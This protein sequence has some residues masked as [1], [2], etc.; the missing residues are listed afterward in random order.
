MAGD[1]A[2]QGVGAF[3]AA[4]GFLVATSTILIVSVFPNGACSYSEA[5]DLICR[6]AH[7]AGSIALFLSLVAAGGLLFGMGLFLLASR[8]RWA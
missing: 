4:L 1:R 3:L 5:G 6:Q 7:D 2:R 8:P